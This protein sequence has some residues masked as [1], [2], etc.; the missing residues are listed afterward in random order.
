M[1]SELA[2]TRGRV[3]KLIQVRE[4][5]ASHKLEQMQGVRMLEKQ[6][7]WKRDGGFDKIEVIAKMHEQTLRC[8]HAGFDSECFNTGLYNPRR[9]FIPQEFTLDMNVEV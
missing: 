5:A 2:T 8:L 4:L 6:A 3:R 9:P 1:V 7:A